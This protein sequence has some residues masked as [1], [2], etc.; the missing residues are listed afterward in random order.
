MVERSQLPEHGQPPLE[1]RQDAPPLF[2]RVWY[3]FFRFVEQSISIFGTAADVEFG[4]T[5]AGATQATA[6]PVAPW[7]LVTTV[8]INSG[9]ILEAG[10]E[11]TSSRVWNRGLNTLNIYPPIGCQIDS[12]GLNAPYQLSSLNSQEFSQVGPT[13]WMSTQL[14]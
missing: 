4:V 6:T 12:L 13:Q 11:G 9:I 2:A 5:A 3:Q 1:G 7:S 8:P 14:A 10:G